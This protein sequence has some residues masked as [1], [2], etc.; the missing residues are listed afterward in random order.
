MDNN[1][2]Q[3][4]KDP[5]LD[6]IFSGLIILLPF[7][8]QY[9][10]IGSTISL[11]ELLLIICLGL[12][13]LSTRCIKKTKINVSIFIFY[14]VV[15]LSAVINSFFDYFS[16][17][18]AITL[19][20]RMVFYAVLIYEARLHFK[21][22]YVSKFYYFFVFLASIYLLL[23]WVYHTFIGGYLPIYIN[24]SLLFPPEARAESLAVYYR[25][26][27]RPSSLFLEP[28]YYSKFVLPGIALLVFK[29][30]K[31]KFEILTIVVSCVAL[32][33]STAN[34]AIIGLLIIFIIKLLDINMKNSVKNVLLKFLL[35]LIMIATFIFFSSSSHTSYQSDRLIS[36]GS[37]N[38]RIIRGTII[39]NELPFFHQ[40]FGVGI[41]N[42]GSYVIENGIYTQYDET[43]LNYAAS[44]VQLLVCFG[45]IGFVVFL[46]A[47]IMYIPKINNVKKSVRTICYVQFFLLVFDV[48]YSNI[49]FSSGFAFSIIILE[50]IIEEN[51]IKG[52]YDI[53]CR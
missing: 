22:S 4:R 6:I 14:I 13:I 42:L 1:P 24:Y 21:L 25:W 49:L 12:I 28:S 10:G 48:I 2:I 9:K 32:L 38:Q 51:T 52:D 7:F 33:M 31:S 20:L 29:S 41:N 47:M 35:A 44:S 36:G 45:I 30:K 53:G 15:L 34:S 43:N 27:F 23:Q 46:I 8:V 39:F 5:R 18:A 19:I 37:I 16:T 40:I 3:H 11:G 50:S 17:T 26:A